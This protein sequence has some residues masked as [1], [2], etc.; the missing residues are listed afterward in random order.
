MAVR[1]SPHPCKPR[2]CKPRELT[3]V[4]GTEILFPKSIEYYNDIINDDIN[5]IIYNI[6]PGKK[7]PG[8]G[9]H[10]PGALGLALVQYGLQ[11]NGRGSRG[12]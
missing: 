10:L 4:S 8:P 9:S 7:P 5:I 2:D 11:R 3:T 12:L 1:A 6:I